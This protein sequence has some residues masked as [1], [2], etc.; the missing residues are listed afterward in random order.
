MNAHDK[1]ERDAWRAVE[2]YKRRIRRDSIM[3]GIGVAF[4]YTF[5][6]GWLALVGYAIFKLSM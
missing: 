6:I 2:E 1:V 5:A 4:A 3:M